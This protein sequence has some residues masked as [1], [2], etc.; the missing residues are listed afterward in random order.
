MHELFNGSAASV[1]R[2]VGLRR[3]ATEKVNDHIRLAHEL[4]EEG[5]NPRGTL[6]EKYSRSRGLGLNSELRSTAVRF[7]PACA[8]R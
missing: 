1:A 8:W 3:S 7:H 4:W 2:A 6:A 5:R